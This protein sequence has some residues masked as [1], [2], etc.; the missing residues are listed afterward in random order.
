LGAEIPNTDM[1][2][3]T[4]KGSMKLWKFELAAEVSTYAAN[5]L[6]GNSDGGKPVSSA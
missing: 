5:D 6:G 1:S 3:A 4:S 2:A